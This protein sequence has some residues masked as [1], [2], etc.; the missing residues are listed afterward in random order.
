MKFFGRYEKA[1][2]TYKIYEQEL[3]SF[4]DKLR[5]ETQ[6]ALRIYMRIMPF[7]S[8]RDIIHSVKTIP[9]AA[10]IKDEPAMHVASKE[11]RYKDRS[12]K[13]GMG[14]LEARKVTKFAS[15][16]MWKL[17]VFVGA[18]ERWDTRWPVALIWGSLNRTK[19]RSLRKFLL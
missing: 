15:S 12:R 5:I 11:E 13:T 8:I 1:L 6:V 17:W 19:S 16:K 14:I 10:G 9:Q 7:K 2:T 3:K 4:L 18:V